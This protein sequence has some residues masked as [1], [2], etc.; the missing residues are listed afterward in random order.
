MLCS[1]FSTRLWSLSRKSFTEQLIPL[2]DK[3]SLL[4]STLERMLQISSRGAEHAV[5]CVAAE[6]YRFLVAGVMQAAKVKGP[7]ILEPV[8]RKEH[9]SH[10]G[11]G[12]FKGSTAR[13]A[14]GLP[15]YLKNVTNVN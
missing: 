10:H 15:N 9:S 8:T 3:K 1:G 14:A 11:A 13:R 7:I 6:V 4:Q 5:I 12:S 2:L